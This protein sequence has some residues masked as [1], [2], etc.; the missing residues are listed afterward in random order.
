LKFL[1]VLSVRV[2]VDFAH[3]VVVASEADL[4]VTVVVVVVGEIVVASIVM[5]IAVVVEI[6]EDL[7]PSS[8]LDIMSLSLDFHRQQAGRT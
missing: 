7:R 4:I 1:V 2:E 3:V 6:V 5:M 8:R